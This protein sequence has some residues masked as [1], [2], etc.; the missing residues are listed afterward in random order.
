MPWNE[1][2][3]MD[4]RLVA[5]AVLIEPVSTADSLPTGKF[6]G[7][8]ADLGFDGGFGVVIGSRDQ[9]LT[10]VI[11]YSAEQGIFSTDQESFC[12]QFR[13]KTGNYLVLRKP[14]ASSLS[15]SQSSVGAMTASSIRIRS[16]GGT[17]WAGNVPV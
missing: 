17:T 11:P 2:S 15:T 7:N 12:H 14:G 4:E 1:S 9:V 10:T 6:T 5:D 3:V 13:G 16:T 8:F